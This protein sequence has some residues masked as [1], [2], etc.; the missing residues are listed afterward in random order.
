[1]SKVRITYDLEIEHTD[2]DFDIVERLR[3][4]TFL[5]VEGRVIQLN[6]YSNFEELEEPVEIK[7][8]TC[9][10]RGYK[11]E[12]DKI[13]NRKIWTH[14]ESCEDKEADFW[15]VYAV[16]DDGTEEWL[17]DFRTREDAELFADEKEE[18]SK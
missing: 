13:E 17:A 9:K 10:V 1:M 11:E 15:G 6:D 8:T 16:Q 3:R 18:R 2:K 4:A 14:I 12:I 7:T 5:Q